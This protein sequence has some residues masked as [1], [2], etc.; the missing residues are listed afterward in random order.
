M[1]RTKMKT[2]KKACYSGKITKTNRF[3]PNL[4][5]SVDETD[6]FFILGISMGFPYIPD[7]AFNFSPRC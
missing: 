5:T 7:A 1:Q 3:F 4:V 2:H 6:H